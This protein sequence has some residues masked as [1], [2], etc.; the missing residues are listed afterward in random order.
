[1]KNWKEILEVQKKTLP[2][3]KWQEILD[4][5]KKELQGIY[6]KDAIIGCLLI[7]AALF[8]HYYGPDFV[9][10]PKVKDN[11]KSY[12]N[13]ILR[14]IKTDNVIKMMVLLD[15]WIHRA[16]ENGEYGDKVVDDFIKFKQELQKLEKL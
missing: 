5:Y 4:V 6:D 3:M 12:Y 13:E 2:K 14:S 9:I 10:H 1:M 7:L 8:D 15:T 11:Y 16:H